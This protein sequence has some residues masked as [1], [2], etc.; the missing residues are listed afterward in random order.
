MEFEHVHVSESGQAC[1]VTG[2]S[3]ETM[4][5]YGKLEMPVRGEASATE[6]ATG[7]WY[8]NRALVQPEGARGKGLGTQLLKRLLETISRKPEFQRVVVEPGGYGGNE[9][10]QVRFYT[11][12]GFKQRDVA[13]HTY[14][15]EKET[16]NV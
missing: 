7:V 14:I 9:E 16:S 12:N 5:A 13:E 6:L 1:I 15:W 3:N 8:L 10:Q 2:M 11:R 4:P